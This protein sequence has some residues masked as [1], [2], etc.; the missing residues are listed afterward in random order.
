[1]VRV[2]FLL[3]I[4]VENEVDFHNTKKNDIIDG[5]N[6][7]INEDKQKR[8]SSRKPSFCVCSLKNKWFILPSILLILTLLI[9][10][11]VLIK[12]NRINNLKD[13]FRIN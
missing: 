13:N 4:V 9:L 2:V 8:S 11:V 3:N 10:I 12:S 1:M 7:T 5:E 6:Q